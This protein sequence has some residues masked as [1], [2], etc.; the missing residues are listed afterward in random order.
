MNQARPLVVRVGALISDPE[1][2]RR[3]I[4]EAGGELRMVDG[5]DPAATLAALRDAQII[6]NA[7]GV[8]FTAELIAQL[9]A[10]QAVIQN[11]VGYDRID[12]KAAT[13]RD[14]MVANLP[15]YCIEEVSDHAVT[16]VLA[17][18][19]RLPRQ[20]KVVREGRW[21][22][23]GERPAREIIGPVNRLSECTL[24]IVG[25]GNIGRLVARKTRGIFAR[26]IAAD[27]YVKPETAAQHGVA[28]LPLDDVLREAD[29]VTLHV[30]LTEETRHLIDAARLALMKPTAFLVNTCRG[31]IVDEA[32]LIAALRAGKLAGAGLDVFEREPIGADH[33]LAAFD[34][35]ILTPH[36]AVYSET[37]MEHWRTDPFEDAARILKGYYPRGL[38]N[39]ELKGRLGR[40]ETPG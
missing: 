29:Y 36:L 39:R 28:L 33:P 5:K 11:S 30:L 40:Q 13:A 2:E 3:L 19:R 8:Q 20:E 14:V 10:C 6:I 26:L 7:G 1:P 24:G 23:A 17:S 18:A 38:I 31:P 9:P 16:L 22:K 4:D 12:V 34:N 27:P 32:A 37:A 15:D 21:G 35:V 25:F